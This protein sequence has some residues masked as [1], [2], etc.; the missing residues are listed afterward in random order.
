MAETLNEFVQELAEFVGREAEAV[1]RYFHA[2]W[3]LPVAERVAAGRC[4]DGLEFAGV[5]C[6]PHRSAIIV[7]NP[8]IG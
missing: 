1:R 2:Q 7:R 3:S 4:A 5:K 6:E 8:K